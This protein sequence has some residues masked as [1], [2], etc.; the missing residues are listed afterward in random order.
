MRMY[1]VASGQYDAH[2]V[3]PNEKCRASLERT[4]LSIWMCRACRVSIGSK[5][6]YELCKRTGVAVALKPT[7]CRKLPGLHRPVA[8]CLRAPSNTRLHHWNLISPYYYWA[9]WTPL[10]AHYARVVHHCGLYV[11]YM[12][13]PA[14]YYAENRFSWLPLGSA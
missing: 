2:V 14:S 3:R 4:C 9:T 7:E 12:S 11:A 10:E 13:S 6:N 1:R 8:S 5:P